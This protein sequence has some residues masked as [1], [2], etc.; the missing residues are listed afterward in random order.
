MGAVGKTAVF[1]IMARF[2][3]PEKFDITKPDSWPDWRQRFG[4]FRFA[5]KLNK[6][7]EETQISALIYSMGRRQSMCSKLLMPPK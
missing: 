7:D 4:R 3:P 1:A 5:S 6:D 2:D